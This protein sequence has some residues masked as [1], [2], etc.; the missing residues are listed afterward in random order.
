MAEEYAAADEST[1]V[2]PAGPS[3]PSDDP[4]TDILRRG[5]PTPLAQAIEAEV[6]VYVRAPSHLK[7]EAGRHKVYT[8]KP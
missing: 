7:D 5:V 8:P 3:A 4:L 2:T 6:A 1:T